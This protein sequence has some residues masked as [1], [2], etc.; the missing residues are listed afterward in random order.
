MKRSFKCKLANAESATYHNR[1]PVAWAALDRQSVSKHENDTVFI[2]R[3]G[4]TR[5]LAPL[6]WKKRSDCA[7]EHHD[8]LLGRN[9]RLLTDIS[10][11]YYSGIWK[12]PLSPSC[13]SSI[14]LDRP[15]M[16]DSSHSENTYQRTT[17]PRFRDYIRSVNRVS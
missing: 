13:Q 14:A 8:Q 3:S 5:S 11:I 7:M 15:S 2:T 16:N 4:F 1:D 9:S 12:I 17:I 6:F 10:D